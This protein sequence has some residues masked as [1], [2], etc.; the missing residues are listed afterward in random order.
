MNVSSDCSSFL[1]ARSQ[2]GK[3]LLNS[4]MAYSIN[5][6]IL[7]TSNSG[8]LSV[9]YIVTSSVWI[10]LRVMNRVANLASR[11]VSSAA[12]SRMYWSSAKFSIYNYPSLFLAAPISRVRIVSASLSFISLSPSKCYLS[13]AA[14][15]ITRLG[16]VSTISPLK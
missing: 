1:K 10:M 13:T 2:P 4:R 14:S 12:H 3:D 6:R 15:P 9:L 11:V 8:I 5:S 16:N 7:L